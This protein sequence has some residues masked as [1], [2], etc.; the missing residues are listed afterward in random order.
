M[1]SIDKVVQIAKAIAEYKPL[2]DG[3]FDAEDKYQYVADQVNE[4]IDVPVLSEETEQKLAEAIVGIIE[5]YI[6]Y[7]KAQEAGE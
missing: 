2:L 1:N 7:K 6:I 5:D 3:Y 4:L